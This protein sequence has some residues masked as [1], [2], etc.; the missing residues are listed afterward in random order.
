MDFIIVAIFYAIVAVFG[1]A[2][3]STLDELI[4]DGQDGFADLEE[5]NA[6]DNSTRHN[7]DVGAL[8]G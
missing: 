7:Q 8:R 1:F 4:D 2:A 5:G 6:S 3:S